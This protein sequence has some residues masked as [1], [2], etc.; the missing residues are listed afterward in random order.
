MTSLASAL[1]LF[2]GGAALISRSGLA[3]LFGLAALAVAAFLA[4]GL[5]TLCGSGP[6]ATCPLVHLQ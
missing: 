1:V 2:F 6:L 4:L 3:R 5:V